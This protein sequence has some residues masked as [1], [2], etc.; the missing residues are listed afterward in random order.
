VFFFTPQWETCVSRLT[1]IESNLHQVL[2]INVENCDK[3]EGAYSFIHFDSKWDIVNR[4]G[5]WSAEDTLA[6]ELMHNKLKQNKQ[7]TEMILR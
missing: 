4:S 5:P 1:R 7:F 2:N 3:G 6:L